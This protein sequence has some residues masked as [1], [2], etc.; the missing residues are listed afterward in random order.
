[1]M[2]RVVSNSTGVP[3]VVTI[4]PTEIKVM[5]SRLNKAMRKCFRCEINVAIAENSMVAKM[6]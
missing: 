3:M 1:M 4:S 5:A 6:I 2:N